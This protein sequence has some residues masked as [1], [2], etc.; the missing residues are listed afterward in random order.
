MAEISAVTVGRANQL[1]ADS[2]NERRREVRAR[3]EIE[4]A[5][6]AQTARQEQAI[7]D[8]AK[9]FRRR[10]QTVDDRQ[11]TR[12]ANEDLFE[13]QREAD[14]IKTSDRRVAFLRDRVSGD[15][16]RDRAFETDPEE[17]EPLPLR[18][19]VGRVL[20]GEETEIRDRLNTF[21]DPI[22]GPLPDED[23]QLSQGSERQ[24]ADAAAAPG[25]QQEQR[26]EDALQGLVDQE[27]TDQLF[28]DVLEGERAVRLTDKREDDRDFLVRQQVDQ[29]VSEVR[30]DQ[31]PFNPN[32]PRG[33][34]VDVTG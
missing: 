8:Q 28:F 11:R 5:R 10:T 24:D 34:I 1:I 17:F 30:I 23:S 7:E 19:S 21:A 31:I 22:V 16:L 18:E 12:Q 9:A 33:S 13:A 32:L 6:Q 4:Q 3:L 15:F 27:I 20:I 14:E 29:Q 26:L 25:T 2:S